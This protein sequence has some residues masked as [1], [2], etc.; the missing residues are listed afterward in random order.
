MERPV[1]I[2]VIE[3][4]RT[5]AKLVRLVLTEDGYAVD[6]AG[7]GEEGRLLGMLHDYDGIVL[8]LGLGDRH[9]TEILQELRRAGR[10]TP[11]LVFTGRD[12]SESIVRVLDAGADEYVVKPV[13]NEE[14]RARVRALVRRGGAGTRTTEQLAAGNLT[15]NRLTRRVRAGDREL[16]L[17]ARELAL[18][19][20]LLLRAGEVVT[21][22]E[23]LEKVWDMHFD[24]GSN[25]IDAHIARLRRKLEGAGATAT[26]TA[27]RGF[28]FVLESGG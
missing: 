18:L 12:E 14:L 25:V 16:A 11:V 1:R 10:T 23:L 4:D 17:T 13:S 8:D 21:R 27:R 3:D 26:V 5:M 20:H 24:P 7:S 9:G 6:V 15:L 22:S 2:L 19:E 28:G